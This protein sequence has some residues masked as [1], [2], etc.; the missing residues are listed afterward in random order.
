M[1]TTIEYALMAGGAYFST[2]PDENKFP[3]PNGW[4]STKHD[5]PPGGSGFEPI[6]FNELRQEENMSRTVA[7]LCYSTGHV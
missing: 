4:V 6:F 2:R 3:V 5:N 1:P 7:L